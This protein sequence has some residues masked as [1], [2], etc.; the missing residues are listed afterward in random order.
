MKF[1]IIEN[2]TVIN[3]ISAPSLEIAQALTGKTCIEFSEGNEI[4]P[5]L[6]LGSFIGKI[7]ATPTE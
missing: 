1:G 3:V 4:D 2:N 6:D 5:S 7:S